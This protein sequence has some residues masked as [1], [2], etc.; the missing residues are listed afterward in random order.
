M[1]TDGVAYRVDGG[2]P[3]TTAA[4]VTALSAALPEQRDPAGSAKVAVTEL[5]QPE[6]HTPSLKYRARVAVAGIP[7][8]A[9]LGYTIWVGIAHGLEV[10]FVILGS[11][12]FF[13]GLLLLFTAYVLILEQV[14]LTLRGITVVGT[15]GFR[16]K[17]G[18]AWYKFTDM[19]GVE[20]THRGK[21]RGRHNRITYDPRDPVVASSQLAW[22]P[23]VLKAS[24]SLASGLPLLGIGSAMA[25]LIVG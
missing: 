21:N 6:R 23:V 1:L 11:V 22:G 2:N 5:E 14:V 10:I 12:P 8:L 3:T 24:A 20:R 4:F 19:D 13:L 15:F 9:Y 7:V 17:D 18:A 25:F 16:T